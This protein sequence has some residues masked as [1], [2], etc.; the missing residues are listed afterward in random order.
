MDGERRLVRGGEGIERNGA[1]ELH[2]LLCP[3]C[4]SAPLFLL[5]PAGQVTS[6]HHIESRVLTNA[7]GAIY[8]KSFTA[9]AFLQCFAIA[10][11]H[12]LFQTIHIGAGNK[13]N[14]CI[15]RQFC[16]NRLAGLMGAISVPEEGQFCRRT[17]AKSFS[18]IYT[19]DCPFRVSIS[20]VFLDGFPPS[21]KHNA[22]FWKFCLLRST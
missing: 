4:F 10:F 21:E 13:H 19:D 3:I 6:G 8:L 15:H 17:Y 14:L 2:R 5:A 9:G 1:A 16:K 18:A 7:L 20:N 12:F 11:P 22:F